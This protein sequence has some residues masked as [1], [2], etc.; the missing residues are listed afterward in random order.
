MNRYSVSINKKHSK[1]IFGTSLQEAYNFL[2]NTHDD[3]AEWGMYPLWH[4]EKLDV[5]YS[6]HYKKYKV[7]IEL[8]NK[9]S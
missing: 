9:G 2:R 5:T 8:E 6:V 3:N 7:T 4:G 1:Y